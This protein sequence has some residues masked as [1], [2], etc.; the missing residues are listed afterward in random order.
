MITS[1][2]MTNIE[3]FTVIAVPVLKLLSRKVSFIKRKDN[4]KC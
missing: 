1:T 2:Q 3:I 4:R